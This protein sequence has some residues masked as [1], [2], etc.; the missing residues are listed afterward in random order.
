MFGWEDLAKDVSKVYQSLPESE[1]ENT[2]AY[3]TNYG[4]A[5]AIEYYSKKYPLPKV[6]CPHNSYWYWWPSHKK[7][8]TVIL[9]G[10]EIEDY[11]DSL[12]KVYEVGIHITRYAMPYENN[13]RLF[14]GHGLKR[15]IDEIRQRVKN[16]I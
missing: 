9:I 3:C 7:Y 1:R 14:I 6:V 10:G 4:K 11:S 2:F 16:F 8:T 5:G 13:L 12:D 15:P